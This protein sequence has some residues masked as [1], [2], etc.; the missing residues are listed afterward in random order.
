V[1]V[2]VAATAAVAFTHA[3]LVAVVVAVFVAVA[4]ALAAAVAVAVLVVVAVAAAG[5][6]SVRPLATIWRAIHFIKHYF[7]IILPPATG[8]HS[9]PAT[10][11]LFIV[12]TTSPNI[13]GL[14]R[15]ELDWTEPN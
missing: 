5:L 14:T 12:P 4:V 6:P 8:H 1:A 2:A 11:F 10:A 13:T 15:P 9:I 7:G 3:L